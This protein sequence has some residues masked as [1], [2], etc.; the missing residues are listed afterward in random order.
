RRGSRTAARSAADTPPA[1]PA[2][3]EQV[4]TELQGLHAVA[5]A[6]AP[7]V[8]VADAT[9]ARKAPA[10]K[11]A[12]EAVPAAPATP[13][14]VDATVEQAIPVAAPPEGVRTRTRAAA[15]KAK[16]AERPRLLVLDTH[17]LLHDPSSLFRF[18]EHDVFLPMMTLEELD[19]NKKGMSEVARNARQVS[20]TLDALIA[21]EPSI[22][23]GVPLSRLGNR[24]A[25]GRLRL[26]TEA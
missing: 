16:G 20:R 9:P 8:A 11:R 1:S 15:A 12:R 10:R 6:P 23:N 5:P 3:A 7:A 25:R 21:D 24:D 14:E 22:A 19:H 18:Q 4:Q 13:V 17:V 2:P 26:Q